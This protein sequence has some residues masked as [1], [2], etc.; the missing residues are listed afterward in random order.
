[1]RKIILLSL[2][3]SCFVP[4]DGSYY[5]YVQLKDKNNTNFSLSNPASY[6]S[7]RAIERRNYYNIPMDSTDLPVNMQYIRQISDLGIHVHCT[8]KW[9]NGVTVL[10]KDTS[11]IASIRTLP[12]VQFTQYTGISNENPVV[13]V[14]PSKIKTTDFD[15]GVA[16][17]QID[18]M[19][20]RIWHQNGFNGET[21]HIAVIDAGFYGVN[22]NPAF[23]TLRDEN[24]L[25]GT[26]DF[27]NPHSNIYVEDGH[28]ALVLSTM[29]AEIDGTFVGTAPKAS[30]WLLRTEAGIGEYLY[31]PDFWISGIEFADSAGVDL[32]TT[33]LGY[34]EFDDPTMNYSYSQLDGKS[35]RA[36]I[37]ADMAYQKGIILLNSAGNEGN[38][39][40]KYISVPA[41]A[42]GVITVGS[43]GADG[44][45][46]AFSSFGPSAD[47][48][49]KPE[50][51]AIGS[52]S[53]FVTANGTTAYGN[54]TSFATPILAGLTACYLQA[55]KEKNPVH[56]LDELRNHLYQSAHLYTMPTNQMGYGIPDFSTV[57][58][59]LVKSSLL[60]LPADNSR[61]AYKIL[62]RDDQ[63]LI[64][65]IPTTDTNGLYT[66][67]IY[68]VS[69]Q[70]QA[71]IKVRNNTVTV[72]SS[73]FERGI[74]LL[75]FEKASP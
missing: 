6:L 50:L 12:F 29:A 14:A 20:G 26:K 27:V 57:Y 66:A 42:K 55:A 30:Y 49:I 10:V 45:P 34:T 41:D 72:H 63:P 33:S 4:M 59:S 65:R 70:L 39:A 53:A 32:A 28:G 67:S 3:F 69:G 9:L 5:F 11:V 58:D 40:W 8:T 18:Q 47:N 19:N 31:E 74:Y 48:R 62:I 22:T 25:L 23:Q 61:M 16:A 7:Q 68:S 13:P 24:R 21:I 75:K 52:S 46:S 35:I 51:C 36:S 37:A 44:L 71:K 64:F 56:T 2:L 15:Y 73:E 54:G 1:M 43:V 60:K 17:T 38:K